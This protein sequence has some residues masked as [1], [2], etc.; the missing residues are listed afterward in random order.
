MLF[1]LWTAAAGIALVR[2]KEP[3]IVR[4]DDD[5]VAAAA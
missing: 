3:K 5:A 4:A 2:S 1:L